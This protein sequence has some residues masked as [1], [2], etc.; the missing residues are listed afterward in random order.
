M[1]SIVVLATPYC[2]TQASAASISRSLA[3][4]ASPGS[5]TRLRRATCPPVVVEPVDQSLSDKERSLFRRFG[6]DGPR[7]PAGRGLLE[8][9]EQPGALFAGAPVED[10]VH[11]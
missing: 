11:R 2:S 5:A 1:S 4:S 7:R 9:G 3:A 6:P 8:G 10:P